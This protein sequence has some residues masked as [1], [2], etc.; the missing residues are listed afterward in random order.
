MCRYFILNKNRFKLF[1]FNELIGI[2]QAIP[3][4]TL[5]TDSCVLFIN[6]TTADEGLYA[7][8]IQIEDFATSNSTTAI[9]SVP[10]QFLVSIKY[11]NSNC[12]S[13]PT[14]IGDLPVDACIIDNNNLTVKIV[15][16]VGCTSVSITDIQILATG[17]ASSRMFLNLWWIIF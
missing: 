17:V 11:I 3:F 1:I 13:Y 9:S 2:C 5:L 8:A 16:K 7:A 4:G 14:I 6:A 10:L 12:T 15:T